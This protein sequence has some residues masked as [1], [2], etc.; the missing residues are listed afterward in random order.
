MIEFLNVDPSE[1]FLEIVELGRAE[2]INTKEQYVDLVDEVIER[3]RGF[4]EMHD[5]SS[6]VGMAEALRGRF[7]EYQAAIGLDTEQPQL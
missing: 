4:G 2:G 6:T 1:I 7:A 3:H 5:D